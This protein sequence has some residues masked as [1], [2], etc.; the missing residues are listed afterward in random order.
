[1]HTNNLMIVCIFSF[2]TLQ[3]C[4]FFYTFT[5]THFN[6]LYH[7]QNVLIHNKKL[8]TNMYL[9]KICFICHCSYSCNSHRVKGC[10][11]LRKVISKTFL[12]MSKFFLG[13]LKQKNMTILIMLD[14]HYTNKDLTLIGESCCI[15]GFSWNF[16]IFM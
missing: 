14:L 13:K 7:S 11:F 10:V 15:R 2:E 16:V 9:H 1:M 6:P 5:T 4:I 3:A 12:S 8:S